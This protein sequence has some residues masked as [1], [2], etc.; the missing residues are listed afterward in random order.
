MSLPQSPS[1]NIQSLTAGEA[2]TVAA[3]VRATEAQTEAMQ[4]VV[5]QWQPQLT[6]RFSAYDATSTDGL[7]C[8][9]YYGAIFDGRHVYACPIR[10]HR[11]RESVHGHVL[12]CDTHGDFHDP[13]AWEAY[14]AGGT[15]G[16]NTVCYYGAAFDG[17]HVI[18][19]PRDDSNGYHS[20]IL[21]YDTQGLFKDADAWAPVHAVL[22]QAAQGAAY[23]GQ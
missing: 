4:P 7:I 2:V 15:D 16:L 22:P 20:R 5:S 12:R 18:F 21:R 23:E 3:T 10:S 17:R 1:A 6:P 9:G 8:S 14:D 19:A 11:E 13:S